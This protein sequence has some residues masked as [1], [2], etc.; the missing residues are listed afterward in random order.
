M[1]WNTL[2]S[3]IIALA[4][5]LAPLASRSDIGSYVPGISDGGGGGG[6]SG[7][8]GWPSFESAG[9][10]GRPSQLIVIDTLVSAIRTN[11]PG[12]ESQ[13]SIAGSMYQGCGNANAATDFPCTT[14]SSIETMLISLDGG[15]AALT[16]I[17]LS[18]VVTDPEL[19]LLCRNG[20]S[21]AHSVGAAGDLLIA[22]AGENRA[23]PVVLRDDSTGIYRW[24][25]ISSGYNCE[26]R[27][28]DF[29]TNWEL[30]F[31]T[32]ASDDFM[33]AYTDGVHP[34]VY[35]S[36]WLAQEVLNYAW[37]DIYPE[38]LGLTNLIPNG[39]METDCTGSEAAGTP[40]TRVGTGTLLDDIYDPVVPV[41][42]P[43]LGLGCV[44]TTP[45]ASDTLTTQTIT[46]TPGEYY[47]GSVF[48]SL[49][50]VTATDR[51][52]TIRIR[53][54]AGNNITNAKF[55]LAG[56]SGIGAAPAEVIDAVGANGDGE[57][58][59]QERMCYG[60]CIVKFAFQMQNGD[61]G[62]DVQLATTQSYT[63]YTDELWVRKKIHQDLE[64]HYVIADGRANLRVFTDSRGNSAAYERFPRALDYMLG[65]TT[66]NG[67]VRASIRPDLHLDEAPS[68]SA[69][70]VSGRKLGDI[71]GDWDGN[72]NYAGVAN[73]V[74][75]G[76]LIEVGTNYCIG[77]F[78]VNDQVSGSRARPSSSALESDTEANR[79]LYWLDQM[80]AFEQ[81]AEREGCIPILVQD[82]PHRG[83]TPITSC[84]NETGTDISCAT[85]YKTAWENYFHNTRQ[86]LFPM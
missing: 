7:L 5:I 41:H 9:G 55:W 47:V 13:A 32:T 54:N 78:G 69:S 35:A 70:W 71:V 37:E 57:W 61:T 48:F 27:T 2:P 66:V 1:N 79:H 52:F 62:F 49:N 40:W 77:L 50:A 67:D 21:F 65:Y 12:H 58:N 6:G 73:T 81:T 31:D 42:G 11:G 14:N 15:F 38:P 80:R 45:G 53:D 19:S 85:W 72:E 60:G 46:A 59:V 56:S 84:T 34:S 30:A 33:I 25:P 75:L 43:L 22:A 28:G 74:A 82:T 23:V 24:L 10:T 68:V 17:V 83:N 8:L 44:L 20:T 51:S 86:S 63:I 26:A 36:R 3:A 16:G 4:F 39:Y 76:D 64:R 29:S 18:P